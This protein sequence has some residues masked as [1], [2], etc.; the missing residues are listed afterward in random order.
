MQQR[1]DKLEKSYRARIQADNDTGGNRGPSTP[2]EEDIAKLV[3]S[4]D[5]A[6][7][8]AAEKKQLSEQ[9]RAQK[10]EAANIALA[11]R[12]QALGNGPAAGSRGRL[13]ESDVD[14]FCGSLGKLRRQPSLCAAVS[15]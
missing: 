1:W 10:A 9:E 12:N 7:K 5:A 14:A 3:A 6:K 15:H 8:E 2:L 4:V 11:M 13:A